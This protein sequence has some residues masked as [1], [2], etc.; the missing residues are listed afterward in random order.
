VA[1]GDLVDRGKNLHVGIVLIPQ[2]VVVTSAFRACLSVVPDRLT[3]HTSHFPSPPR[4]LYW[5][6]LNKSTQADVFAE[7]MSATQNALDTCIFFLL[8]IFYWVSVLS[9]F[10]FMVV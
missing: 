3:L 7:I 1:E 10:L 4:P 2:H 5:Y 9:V 6:S 8:S